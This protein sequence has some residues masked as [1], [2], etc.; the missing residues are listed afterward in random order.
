[1][2]KRP[3]I[4]LALGA[5]GARGLAHI[6]VLRILEQ[7]NIPIDYIAG[8]SVGAL[9][10]A[11]YALNPDSTDVEN[12]IL[13]YISSAEYKKA[14]LEH[15]TK[16]KDADSFFSH[17]VTFLKERVIINLAP[18]RISLVSNKKLKQALS[19]LIEDSVFEKT[20][21]P[22]CA[23]ASDLISGKEIVLNSG[24]IISAIISSGSIPG[25]LPPVSLS[26]YYLLDGSVVQSVPVKTAFEMGADVVIAIDVSQSLEK[27]SEFDNILEIMNRSGQM[28]SK[29]LTDLQLKQAHVVLKPNVGQYHWSEFDHINI[30]INEGIRE[31]RELLPEIKKKAKRRWITR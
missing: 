2:F 21:I 24:N 13:D 10:G 22:F 19:C 6:G 16:G 17:V 28:T 7:E 11:M 12:K 9:I 20:K 18:S 23:V 3:K 29:A 27:K 5:G 1:M 30:M 8:T 25:F 26:D 31:A 15:I 4:G 14:R